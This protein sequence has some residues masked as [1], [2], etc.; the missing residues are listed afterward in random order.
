MNIEHGTFTPLSFALNGGVGTECSIF[1]KH[2]SERIA[3]D[4]MQNLIYG[5]PG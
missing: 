4:Q 5:S 3:L 1:H 2:F